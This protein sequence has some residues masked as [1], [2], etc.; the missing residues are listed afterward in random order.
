MALLAAR[1]VPLGFSRL[2]AQMPTLNQYKLGSEQRRRKILELMEQKGKVMVQDLVER[3]G[4]GAVTAQADSDALASRGF[5]VR[6]Q[7]GAVRRL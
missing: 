7:G 3:F 5:G 1:G 6:S 4:I 2:R